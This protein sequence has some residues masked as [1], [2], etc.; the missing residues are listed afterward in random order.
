M[1]HL[2]I[3]GAQKVQKNLASIL[4]VFF[5]RAAF[6]LLGEDRGTRSNCEEGESEAHRLR[7]KVELATPAFFLMWFSE[8]SVQ[9]SL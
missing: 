4:Q 5:L 8:T 6:T 7:Q 9:S 2:K 3:G 1:A